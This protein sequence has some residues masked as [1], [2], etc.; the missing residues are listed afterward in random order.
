MSKQKT[1]DSILRGIWITI[2]IFGAL[3]VGALIYTYE[4]PIKQ[5]VKPPSPQCNHD[6]PA[7]WDSL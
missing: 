7:P 4:E 6:L 5:E 3:F 1:V 2:L